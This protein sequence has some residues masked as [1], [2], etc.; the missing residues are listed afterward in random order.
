MRQRWPLE[1]IHRRN[2]IGI[3]QGDDGRE[4]S[5]D[6]QQTDSQHAKGAGA[7]R[8]HPVQKAEAPHAAG[9]ALMVGSGVIWLTMRARTRGSIQA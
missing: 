1:T 9:S 8:H 5:D 6:Q 3:V 4:H 2:R 7:G